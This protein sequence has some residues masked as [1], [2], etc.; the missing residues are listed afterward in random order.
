[1]TTLDLDLIRR[2]LHEALESVLRRH[3]KVTSSLRRERTPLGTDWE[4]NATILENDEVLDALDAEGRQR[5][6]QLLAAISRLTHG[7]YGRCVACGGDIAGA[8]LEA[9]PE[10]THCVACAQAAET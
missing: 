2:R 8:R 3:A 10:A 5:V 6:V 7:D 1:M 4:D 9:L